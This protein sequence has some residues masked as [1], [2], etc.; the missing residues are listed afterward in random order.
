MIFTSS[1]FGCGLWKK[2]SEIIIIKYF[3]LQFSKNNIFEM[4]DNELKFAN[5]C[6]L[7]LST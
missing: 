5:K 7:I 2:V 6:L 1:R 3:Q 4:S